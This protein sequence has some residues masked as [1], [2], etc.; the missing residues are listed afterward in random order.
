MFVFD[1]VLGAR[2]VDGLAFDLGTHG[3]QGLVI[4][5]DESGHG[6]PVACLTLFKLHLTGACVLEVKGQT[7]EEALAL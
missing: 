3:E 2:E 5:A 4:S 1:Q 6:A 7:V